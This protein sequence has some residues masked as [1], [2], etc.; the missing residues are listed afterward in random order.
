MCGDGSQFFITTVV[1]LLLLNLPHAFPAD[2][3][4]PDPT[5]YHTVDRFNRLGVALFPRLMCR[6]I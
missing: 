1:A 6:K 2:N 3:Y 4:W 5:V